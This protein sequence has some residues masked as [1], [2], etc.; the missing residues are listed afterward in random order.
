MNNMTHICSNMVV[1]T[2]FTNLFTF[3]F[4]QVNFL[5]LLLA[6][7]FFSSFLKNYSMRSSRRGAVVNE[8]DEEP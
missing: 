2:L 6:N 3:T 7:P 5:S 4:P 1:G 8:S